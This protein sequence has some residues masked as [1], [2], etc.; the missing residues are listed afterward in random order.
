MASGGTPIITTRENVNYARLCR[1]LIDVGSKVL[2][3]TFNGIHPPG[4]LPA[5][6][7]GTP[8]ESTLKNLKRKKVLNATQWGE[9]YPATPSTVSSS[10]FDITLLMILLR[11][12]CGLSPPRSTDSWDELPPDSDNSLEANIV[13]IKYYRNDVYAHAKKASVDNA[14]FNK[15]WLNISNAILALGKSQASVIDRLKTVRMD[16]ERQECYRRS[17]AKSVKSDGSIKEEFQVVKELVKADQDRRG[18][19]LVREDRRGEGRE[20]RHQW[21]HPEKVV[22]MECYYKSKIYGRGYMKRM[23]GFWNQRGMFERTEQQLAAQAR[24]VENNGYLSEEELNAI[25][26]RVGFS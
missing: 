7:S 3:D 2:R 6:L 22:L 23:L 1:L 18:E 25:K 17:L 9:L 11:N 21:T 12:I 14:N 5:I 20:K 16:V 24:S 10:N 19:E 26:R 15:L 13:R 4:N 8:E